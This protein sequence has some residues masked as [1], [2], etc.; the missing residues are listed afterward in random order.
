MT[1]KK[2]VWVLV[3]FVAVA[4]LAVEG[5]R[6]CGSPKGR[7]RVVGA[8]SGD[9]DRSAKGILDVQTVRFRTRHV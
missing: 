7:P 3:A 5:S 6:R 4:L 2:A 9:W 8:M 1:V